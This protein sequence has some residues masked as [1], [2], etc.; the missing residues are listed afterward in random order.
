MEE[1][2]HI[3]RRVTVERLAATVAVLVAVVGVA[4]M[5]VMAKV[6]RVQAASPALRR[7]GRDAV[8]AQAQVD[9]SIGAGVLVTATVVLIGGIAAVLLIRLRRPTAI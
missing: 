1:L 2:T 7:S 8:W 4:A 3:R 5:V 9:G 6:D